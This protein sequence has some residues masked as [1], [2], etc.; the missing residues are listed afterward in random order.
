MAYNRPY[1]LDEVNRILCD[2]ERR[3]RPDLAAAVAKPG[4]AISLHTEA[5]RDFFS[6]G[7]AKLP[8]K[9][10]ILLG[11]RKHLVQAVHEVLNSVPGQIELAKLND[12]Q[13]KKVEIRGVVLRKGRDF[14]IFTVFRPKAKGAQMSFDWLSTHKGDGYIVQLFILVCKLPGSGREQIHIQ[15]AFPEDYARTL[16]DD[17][18]R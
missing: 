6:R 1:G 17:I 8:A 13:C 7:G 10:S 12:P 18:L 4:H 11:S 14:D 5:R 15:T 3:P 16:G 9:D 2:S